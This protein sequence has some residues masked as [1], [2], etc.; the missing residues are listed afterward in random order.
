MAIQ[1]RAQAGLQ[2]GIQLHLYLHL[3]LPRWAWA[4]SHAQF[5]VVGRGGEGGGPCWGKLQILS[6]SKPYTP[7]ISTP[8]YTCTCI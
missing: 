3:G 1:M 4:R 6:P 7:S 5:Q 2:A 8:L